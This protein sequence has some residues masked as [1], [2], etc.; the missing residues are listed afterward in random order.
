MLTV[1][2]RVIIGLVVAYLA[3]LVLLYLFQNRFLYPAPQD[4]H[5]PAPGFEAVQLSTTDGLTLNAHWQPPEADQP[6][7]VFFHGNASSLAG[8]TE[9]TRLLATQG[10]GVLLVNYRGY[11]GNPG[12][13]SEQGFY[14]DGHAAM[15]FL[16]DKGVRRAR[17]IIIGNSIGSGAATHIANQFNTGALILVSPFASLVEVAS[18]AMPIAPVGL[19]LKDRF[20]NIEKAPDLKMPVLIQHDTTDNVVPYSQGKRLS[21][22]AKTSTFQSFEGSGHQ[23]AYGTEA[24]I[25]QSEWLAEQ[26]L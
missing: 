20:E 21:R 4:V 7:V 6:S 11:G 5:P 10:Y 24:Q 2:L 25:A 1:A 16:A 22:A 14:K 15:A 17:T 8:A 19:L 3:L 13:P 9:A 18:E 12:D 26:G 23:L